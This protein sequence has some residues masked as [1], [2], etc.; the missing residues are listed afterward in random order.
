MNVYRNQNELEPSEESIRMFYS[1]DSSHL[2][3]TFNSC[4]F[5][6]KD[7][8]AFNV[9][10]VIRELRMMHSHI[11]QDL[12]IYLGNKTSVNN[13]IST[14]GRVLFENNTISLGNI[15]IKS[16]EL[17]SFGLIQF[18]DTEFNGA[19]VVNRGGLVLFTFGSC[20]FSTGEY[21]LYVQNALQ[22]NII[23]CQFRLNHYTPCSQR[24]GCL[25]D[26]RGIDTK[27][28]GFS[29]AKS[30]FFP[31]CTFQERD[32]LKTHIENSVFVTSPGDTRE[33]I[34]VESMS[35]VLIACDLRLPGG[36][37]PA[38][39]SAFLNYNGS[40]FVGINTTFDVSAYQGPSPVLVMITKDRSDF[41]NV[42]VMCPELF[43]LV[44]DHDDTGHHYKC[45]PPDCRYDKYQY[46][47]KPLI[48]QDVSY[49]VSKCTPCPIGAKCHKGTRS[50]PNY[51]GYKDQS[52]K[53]TMIRC[54]NGYCCQNDE[55]CNGIDSCNKH[56]T[57]P[58]C[59][60]CKGNWTESLFSPECLLIQ[61]CP[62]GE[63]IVLYIACAATYSLVLM[64]S[65]YVKDVGVSVLKKSRD[66]IVGLMPCLKR[67]PK[68]TIAT[69]KPEPLR[70][71]KAFKNLSTSNK[72]TKT[73]Y[74]LSRCRQELTTQLPEIDSDVDK[75]KNDEKEEDAMKYIQIL[76]YYVQDAALFKVQLPSE[77]QND[78]SIVVKI[79]QF[80]PD[81]LVTL[82]TKVSDLCFSPGTT[83]VT[84]ILFSSFFGPCAMLVILLLYIGQ[85]CLL[86]NK[87][88]PCK[89]F[90][91]RLVQTFLLIVLFSYQKIV[92]GTFTLIQCIDVGNTTILYVQGDIECYTWWQHITE[93]YIV[94][95]IIPVF[96]VLAHAPFYVEDKTMSVKMFIAC[97]LMPVPAM[98]AYH[99]Q[100]L[101][102]KVKAKKTLPLVNESES[103]VISVSEHTVFSEIIQIEKQITLTH[104][105]NAKVD[106]FFQRMGSDTLGQDD[107]SSE[108]D[109]DIGSEYSTDLIRV[110]EKDSMSLEGIIENRMESQGKGTSTV[111]IKYTSKCK[112]ND[113]REAISYV[114]LKHYRPLTICGIRFTWLGIHK[115]YR[116]ILVA[117]NTYITDPLNKLCMMSVVLAVI[118]VANT[119]ARPYK[120]SNTNKVASISYMANI[121]IA[122]LNLF[123]TG[124]V[125]FGCH[126]N[127]SDTE[128]VISYLDEVENVLLIYAPV[129]LFPA[130]LVFKAIRKCRGKKK[131]E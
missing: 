117:C 73:E 96:I 52:E 90:R 91:A 36:S 82:Y 128:A 89:M 102:I 113:S 108:S 37:K 87:S 13:N 106:E 18:I 57:G 80:S 5:S 45:Q 129:V 27:S 12:K 74:R 2:R 61:R 42:Y 19:G 127:C 31:K 65:S 93:V 14:V 46:L 62:A 94:L 114:M 98:V 47:P 67:N 123:K 44:V 95:N 122:S 77:G 58:L 50:L 72:E 79:L 43:D 99:V 30:I 54:P 118:S 109:T 53:I 7:Y 76:F 29:L 81:I 9:I 63:I 85:K 6:N 4:Q 60:K 121:C 24:K 32:C 28:K 111:R 22:V 71:E 59:G 124:L 64:V 51:W 125:K 1:N 38:A 130:A 66:V 105:W 115:L 92:I 40:R 41:K 21:G 88:K 35:L 75:S 107:E 97:C 17:T 70:S 112:F 34:N 11:K 120:E 119:T 68:S 8:Q 15:L 110:R 48:F 104:D 56:R 16:Y 83:A 20:K 103:D 23:N 84:K 33:V 39:T 100:R 25:V 69:Q 101:V 26:V 3:I 10:G 86:S 126:T 55:M 78:E 131:E 49:I 116:V